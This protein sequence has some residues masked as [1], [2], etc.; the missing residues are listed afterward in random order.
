MTQ[1]ETLEM[2]DGWI[3][4]EDDVIELAQMKVLR[5]IIQNL[6]PADWE[7]AKGHA[8]KS[9][10]LGVIRQEIKEKRENIG[11]GRIDV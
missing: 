9:H 10:D 6:S 2:I 8:L 4:T 11:E 3:E 1:S 5:L 7:E